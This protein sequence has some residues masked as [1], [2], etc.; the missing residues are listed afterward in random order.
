MTYLVD[1]V[2]DEEPEY[3]NCV[4]MITD[5]CFNYIGKPYNKETAKSITKELIQRFEEYLGE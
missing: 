3:I 5:T 1:I 4:W 2:G